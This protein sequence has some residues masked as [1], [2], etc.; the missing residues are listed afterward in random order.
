MERVNAPTRNFSSS[1]RSLPSDGDCDGEEGVTEGSE[2][3]EDGD[4][5]T[6]GEE[7]GLAPGW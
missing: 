3:E 6:V 5:V 2:G 7:L 4:G 1:P